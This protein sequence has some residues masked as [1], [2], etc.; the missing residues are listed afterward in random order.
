VRWVGRPDFGHCAARVQRRVRGIEYR[1]AM[2]KKLTTVGNSL[3]L[4]FD[5][6][7]RRMLGLGPS[8]MVKLKT[9]GRRLVIEPVEERD[10]LPYAIALEARSVLRRLMEVYGMGENCF[11]ALAPEFK[12]T[13]AYDGWLEFQLEDANASQRATVIRMHECL[14]ALERGAEWPDAIAEALRQSPVPG[15]PPPRP[16]AVAEGCSGGGEQA[17]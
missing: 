10:V 9:D 6:P 8:R 13:L 16:T 11:R 2:Q 14:A 5:K 12:R 17:G 4:I 3:A 7:L 15:A 1:T